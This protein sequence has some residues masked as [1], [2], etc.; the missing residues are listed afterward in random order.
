MTNQEQDRHEAHAIAERHLMVL[1]NLMSHGIY[2]DNEKVTA[3]LRR[4]QE[5]VYKFTA[6][7][8]IPYPQ[9]QFPETK[10]A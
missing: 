7:T 2:A 5:A 8:A 4:L 6:L 10:A 3:Q 9:E 1:A